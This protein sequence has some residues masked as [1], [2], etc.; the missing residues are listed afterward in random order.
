MVQYRLEYALTKVVAWVAKILPF[1]LAMALGDRI[2]DL[3][4]YVIRIRKKVALANL[5]HALGNEKKDGELKAILQR[6]YRHFGRMLLEFAH[7]PQMTRESIV[8]QI[9][10]ENPAHLQE[11]MLRNRGVLILSGHFG[12]W[13]YL[14]A[15]LANVGAALHCVFKEQKNKAV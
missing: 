11:L 5:K 9:P 1:R 7:L 4:Y 8:N 14:A 10:I 12:N 15:R 2:G 6:N 13:E 3:F